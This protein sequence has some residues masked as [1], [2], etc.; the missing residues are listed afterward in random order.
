MIS[1][2]QPHMGCW[3]SFCRR[4]ALGIARAIATRDGC[5]GIPCLYCT[6]MPCTAPADGRRGRQ[7]A[8]NEGVL[9]TS[10]VLLLVRVCVADAGRVGLFP[11]RHRRVSE[12]DPLTFSS[13]CSALLPLRAIAHPCSTPAP[14]SHPHNSQTLPADE[15]DTRPTLMAENDGSPAAKRSRLAMQLPPGV[16]QRLKTSLNKLRFPRSASHVNQRQQPPPPHLIP[17]HPS[18]LPPLPPASSGE[19][20][21]ATS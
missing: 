10:Q 12:D 16:Q 5:S 18:S 9:H 11:G 3:S 17:P 13:T 21:M 1:S 6:R 7:F 20:G 2:N 15:P 19:S 14:P 8:A 4:P